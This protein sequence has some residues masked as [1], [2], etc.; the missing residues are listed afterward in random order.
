MRSGRRASYIWGAVGLASAVAICG[1]LYDFADMQMLLVLLQLT[2]GLGQL[3]RTSM[4]TQRMS[5][6]QRIQA[7]CW[8]CSFVV[9]AFANLVHHHRSLA[10]FGT[11]VALLAVAGA[12]F[13]TRVL[14]GR[15]FW[16]RAIRAPGLERQPES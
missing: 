15:W 14:D 6:G 9:L 2:T 11:A 7:T 12:L 5:R 10:W 13:A 16:S 3:I 4:T 8:G 1:W